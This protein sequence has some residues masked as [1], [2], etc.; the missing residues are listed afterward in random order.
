[1]RNTFFTAILIGTVF[2]CTGQSVPSGFLKSSVDEEFEM[3]SSSI[4]S[5]RPDSVLCFDWDEATYNW[6]TIPDRK[7]I[8]QYHDWNSNQMQNNSTGAGLQIITH[9]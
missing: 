6:K 5:Y 1:M 4:T 2:T 3:K 9:S 7:E 8:F